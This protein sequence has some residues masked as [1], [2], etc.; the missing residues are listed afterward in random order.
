MQSTL[1][2]SR[3]MGDEHRSLVDRI[4]ENQLKSREGD[5]F[6]E[7]NLHIVGAKSHINLT[8]M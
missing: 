2:T 3:L 6:I 4:A 8:V 7:F 1:G 5:L